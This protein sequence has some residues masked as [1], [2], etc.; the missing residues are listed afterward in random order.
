MILL[1]LAV[2]AATPL[3]GIV[4]AGNETCERAMAPAFRDRAF[5]YIWG[6]W[7]GMNMAGNTQTGHT[8]DQ[9]EVLK[10]VA[11][12]CLAQPKMQLALAVLAIHMRY[13]KDKR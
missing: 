2:A 3:P 1:A 9:H 7:S 8:V 11:E 13:E 4:G 10:D 5:D 12:V 6:V